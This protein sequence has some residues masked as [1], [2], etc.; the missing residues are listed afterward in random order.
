M[1]PPYLL[2]AWQSPH[3][4]IPDGYPCQLLR[5]AGDLVLAPDMA[6]AK[7][8]RQDTVSPSYCEWLNRIHTLIDVQ[9]SKKQQEV[10]AARQ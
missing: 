9:E 3:Q 7:K 10:T 2:Y 1:L 5:S 6:S 4:P 8:H